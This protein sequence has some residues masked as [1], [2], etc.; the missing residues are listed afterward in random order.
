[1]PFHIKKPG[2]P[3][4]A[5]I[6]DVYYKGGSSRTVTYADRKQY[7]NKTT[8]DNTIKNPKGKNGGFVNATVVTE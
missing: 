8:A 3:A 2:V 1:M 7:S 6:G 4:N 5:G